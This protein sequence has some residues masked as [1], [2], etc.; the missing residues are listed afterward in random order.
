MTKRAL[1]H[2]DTSSRAGR[3][4]RGW[5]LLGLILALAVM[6]IM[7]AS[8]APNIQTQ[9]KR[10]KEEEMIYRGQQM[11]EAI[12][13]YYNQGLVG[14]IRLEAPPP[15]GYLTDLRRLRNGITRGVTQVKLVRP[16]A[17]IDPMVNDEWEPVRMRDPRLANALQAYVAY[18]NTINPQSPVTIPPPWMVIAGIFTTTQTINPLGSPAVPQTGSQPA[19]QPSGSTGARSS[20]GQNR[21]SPNG[22]TP[23][24]AR[25][26][27]APN[28]EEGDDDDDDDTSDPLSHLLSSGST[29][30]PGPGSR[31]GSD[32]QLGQSNL[33]IV[34]VAPRLKGKAIRN[35]WGMTN[36]DDWVFIYI[37]PQGA[38]VQNIQGNQPL[39]ISQ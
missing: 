13:R 24:G 15:Y 2:G 5:A 22:N 26:P 6:G 34:G 16:S 12:T 10:D 37:P 35:L 14:Y 1:A 7:L 28:D 29:G 9:V 33:P 3:G 11:A 19:P 39:R 4:D 36:Y 23:P 20:G 32:N 8:V 31:K 38:R 18:M 17:M 21:Q 30:F 25:P 27:G